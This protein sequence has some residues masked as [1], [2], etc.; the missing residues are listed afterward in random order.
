M[1]K[2]PN[3]FYKEIVEKLLELKRLYPSYSM[4]KH[5]A[6]A[7]D[8]YE[9]MWGITDKEFLFAITKY[10]AQMEMDVP[11]E[12]D[13]EEIEKIIE[14]G[15]NLSSYNEEDYSSEFN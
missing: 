3:R 2:K 10:A 6:T 14:D 1:K 5:L 9:D 4:G 13:E 15:L 12:T 7:L 8:E 11:H